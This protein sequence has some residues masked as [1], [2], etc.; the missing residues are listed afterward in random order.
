MI[1]RLWCVLNMNCKLLYKMYAAKKER[2]KQRFS[3]EIL[4]SLPFIPSSSSFFLLLILMSA[5][6][7]HTLLHLCVGEWNGKKSLKVNQ[8]HLL[9]SK[10]FCQCL[11]YFVLN[12][13]EMSAYLY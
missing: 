10:E 1:K 4:S 7:N 11:V 9:S 3:Q 12:S 2:K 13:N 8:G 5:V 6:I